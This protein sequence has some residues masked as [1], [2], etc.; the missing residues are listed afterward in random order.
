MSILVNPLLHQ[1]NDEQDVLLKVQRYPTPSKALKAVS[2]QEWVTRQRRFNHLD[3][4]TRHL[5]HQR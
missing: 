2:Y 4:T 3:V 1:H 5:P